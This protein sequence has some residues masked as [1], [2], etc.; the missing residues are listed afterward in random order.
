V[1]RREVEERWAPSGSSPSP[2]G[3]RSE[4]RNPFALRCHAGLRGD[5]LDSHELPNSR[6]ITCPV[7]ADCDSP[8]NPHLPA[9]ASVCPSI[10]KLENPCLPL[11]RHGYFRPK[12][13]DIRLLRPHARQRLTHSC[14]DM[15]AAR[16]GYRRRPRRRRWL[17]NKLRAADQT[18]TASCGRFSYDQG[19]S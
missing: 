10:D 12:I 17:Q 13:N 16:R 4:I 8:A 19:Q 18:G 2:G 6:L 14:G 5:E 15:A 3:V 9:C 1:F 7:R 11:T